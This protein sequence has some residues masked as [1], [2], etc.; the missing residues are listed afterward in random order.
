MQGRFIECVRSEEE[1]QKPHR[2]GQRVEHGAVIE[3]ELGERGQPR[4]AGAPR[5]AVGTLV[6]QPGAVLKHQA[7]QASQRAQACACVRD[8][9]VNSGP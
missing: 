5:R 4:Q 9:A 1:R 8:A 6:A 2:I 7:A 3:D